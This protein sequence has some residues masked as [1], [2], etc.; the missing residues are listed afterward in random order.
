MIVLRQELP[1]VQKLVPA[2]MVAVSRLLKVG[3]DEAQD[4]HPL[5]VLNI[6]GLAQQKLWVDSGSGSR[7]KV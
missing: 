6:F 1:E 3:V 7:P 4:I 2:S 5:D